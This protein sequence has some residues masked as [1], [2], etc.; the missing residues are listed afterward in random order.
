MDVRIGSLWVHRLE[1]WDLDCWPFVC[2]HWRQPNRC[3]RI[4]C[5]W[6][7]G[8]QIGNGRHALRWRLR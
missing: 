7:W 6:R 8:V 3:R 1:Q 5:L 4:F 2:V